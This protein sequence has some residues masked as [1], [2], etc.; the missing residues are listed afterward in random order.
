[1]INID[2][3]EEANR[4]FLCK[5]PRCKKSCPISTNIPEVIKLFKENKL[6]EAGKILFENNPLSAV[7]AIVCPH[8]KQCFGNCI[9]NNKDT[10]VK[11]YEIEKFISN[12]YLKTLKLKKEKNL[13]KNICVIGAGPAGITASI[14]LSKKGYNVTLFEMKE[15]IGGVLNYGIPDFRLSRDIIENLKNVLLN[16]DVKIRYSSFVGDVLSIEKLK[17]EYD[18]VFISTGVWNPKS[19]NIKGE[20][21][22]NCHYAIDYLSAN[23]NYDLG[24][25]V[26]VIGAGNV[27][28]DASRVAKRNGS[29]NVTVVYRKDFCD[30]V[31]TKTEINE[32]IEDGVKFEVFK[33]PVEITKEG[34]IF[35]DTKK[36]VD[37]NNNVKMVEIKNSEKLMK[38]DSVIIAVGQNPQK[39]F[40]NSELNVCKNNFIITDENGKTNISNVFAGGDVVT[41]AKTVVEAVNG[42]KNISNYI[43]KFLSE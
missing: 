25:N 38:A 6:D 12:N 2:L 31:A 16:L 34:V 13:D 27:S 43:H 23:K 40:K 18:A 10:G 36:E 35:I 20:S 7:C 4:C 42:A 29:K 11:F 22:G 32:A 9:R 14:I 5:V 30:M 3:C 24:D 39:S 28:M 26:I 41:G 1:M 37:K 15:N 8:E 33:S 17:Q 21:L 19:L